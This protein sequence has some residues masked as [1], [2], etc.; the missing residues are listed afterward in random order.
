MIGKGSYFKGWTST[1]PYNPSSDNYGIKDEYFIGQVISISYE[2]NGKVV[3]RLIGKELEILDEDI[4]VEAY[5][6]NINMIKYP[7]PGELVLIFQGFGDDVYKGAFATKYY[8]LSVLS[9]NQSILYNSDP[10]IGTSVPVPMAPLLF[11][12]EYEHR[13]EN[14]LSSLTSFLN[15]PD[16][17]FISTVKDKAS[18]KP[19]EGDVLIQ[20]RFGSSIRLGSTVLSKAT[21]ISEWSK[22]GSVAGDPVVILSTDK[23]R[24]TAGYENI[25]DVESSI[26][27]LT[28]QIVPIQLSTSTTL[29][30]Y[31]KNYNSEPIKRTEKDLTE[32]VA[33]GAG[34]YEQLYIGPNGGFITLSGAGGNGGGSNGGYSGAN[35]DMTGPE[36]ASSVEFTKAAGGGKTAADIQAPTMPGD[37]SGPRVTW[38]NKNWNYII[39]KGKSPNFSDLTPYIFPHGGKWKD[40]PTPKTLKLTPELAIFYA[41]TTQ[42]EGFSAWATWDIS[43]WRIGAGNSK[44]SFIDDNTGKRIEPRMSFYD[45]PELNRDIDPNTKKIRTETDKTYGLI[46]PSR[47]SVWPYALKDGKHI[48]NNFLFAEKQ[49][50]IDIIKREGRVYKNNDGSPRGLMWDPADSSVQ[51]V[52]EYHAKS[53]AHNHIIT[54]EDAMLDLLQNGVESLNSIKSSLDKRA[55]GVYDKLTPATRAMLCDINHAYGNISKSPGS[56]SSKH[57]DKT[58]MFFGSSVRPSGYVTV[59]DALIIAD[60]DASKIADF[61]LYEISGGNKN[62]DW[63]RWKI[64]NGL[65]NIIYE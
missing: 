48:P 27:L 39:D 57:P 8:Y 54:L 32:A 10:Y 15:K 13:Y 21:E 61:I 53:V 45:I 44:F 19:A 56:S 3:V 62:R 38:P 55:P 12:T 37:P 20:G 64:M 11:T 59:E 14:K 18:L 28:N 22:Q 46:I 24:K 51:W 26:Y 58:G 5:P 42:C 33:A 34:T 25:N 16:E 7:L 31:L 9:S 47:M 17:T 65:F 40:K 2:D 41:F 50:L 29:A 1:Q 43:N 63:E 49:E 35:I 23:G 52:K 36:F 30:S 6:S 4:K 60:G